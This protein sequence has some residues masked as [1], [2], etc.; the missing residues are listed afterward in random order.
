MDN[1]IH[2]IQLSEYQTPKSIEQKNK[3]WVMFGDTN[4]HFNYL[5]DRYNNSATNN[6]VINNIA[7]LVY[8]KGLKAK[9]AKLN[10]EM[11]A[12]AVSLFK[13][14]AIKKAIL[15]CKVT[16]NYAF[17]VGFKSNEVVFIE[18]IPIQNLRAEKCN[19]KGIIEA[20]YYSDN[21]E[22]IK[23]FPPTR[24][25]AFGKG[26][27]IQILWGGNYSIGQKYYS[28]ID[29]IGAL[30]YTT[31]EEQIALYLINE[32]ENGF[33]PSSVVNF[34]NGIPD[35]EAQEEISSKVKQTLT[36][37]SGK[38][39]IVAF[40]NDETKK[41]TVDSIP[42]DNAPE[43][44]SYL[45]EEAMR[46]IM[47]GHNVTSPLLFGIATT[48][49]FSS[50]ADE[51]RNS[52]ILFDNMV[53]KPFQT[54]I[55][56]SL[57]EILK[58]ND[59]HLD[60]YFE[61]LQP[62]DAEGDLTV[63]EKSDETLNALN[64]LSPL[65]ANKVLESMT[66]SEIRAL[67]GLK[68]KLN[69]SSQDDDIAQILID[70]GEELGSEWTLI[71]SRDVSYE[72]EDSLDLQI[73]KLNKPTLLEKV[74]KLV[75]TGTARPNAKSEQDAEIDGKKYI[76]RYSYEGNTTD[77]SRQFC[78]KMIQAKK[79]YRKEDIIAMDQVAVNAG[80]GPRGSDT[81]SV[82]LYK[83]GGSCHHRWMRKTFASTTKVDVNNP[84]APTIS[85]NKAESEGFR[86]RNPKEVAMMPKDMPNQGFLP[87]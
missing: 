62:L 20:Y 75:S 55:I 48:T 64:T 60:L 6:A 24:I 14:N 52:F 34:N 46:K 82:W 80:W 79:L 56:E 39:V 21:W 57:K 45:S 27:D 16:G 13:K 72:D 18:H 3:D 83:G 28:N 43:H 67:V 32:V 47:L 61:T 58:V 71:D 4:N 70:K 31:L 15:D 36:G 53:I 11:W 76:V 68:D 35:K 7:K 10:P 38:K 23:K 81:Y 50:N 40:N 73:E 84:N 49:G 78:K 30:P 77:Q 87:K 42:L 66:A 63:D 69:F 29:Y 9:N 86:V 37:S 33:S 17:Q 22:D 65:V 74:V 8:G 44:Y 26:G 41:T 2:F 19:E 85:T 25:P 59:I 51:L 54:S 12:R 5:I 1:N